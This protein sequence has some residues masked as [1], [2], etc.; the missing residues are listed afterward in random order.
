[1]SD[2]TL[3]TIVPRLTYTRGTAICHTVIL[4]KI[5]KSHENSPKITAF[6]HK[7]LWQSFTHVQKLDQNHRHPGQKQ[8]ERTNFELVV[9]AL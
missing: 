8:L 1:M 7:T 6:W 3:Q 4:Q 9:L 5:T 2:V